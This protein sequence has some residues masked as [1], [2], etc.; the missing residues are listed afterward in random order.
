M[1]KHYAI[2]LE[3]SKDCQQLYVF[4]VNN[5]NQLV[6]IRMVIVHNELESKVIINTLALV[7]EFETQPTAN[8]HQMKLITE[9]FDGMADADDLISIDMEEP[10][11]I[12]LIEAADLAAVLHSTDYDDITNEL[13]NGKTQNGT[14]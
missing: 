7:K 1:T 13:L 9:I 3:P 12:N 10:G 11:D 6:R 4:E 5:L 14:S 2:K 8:K